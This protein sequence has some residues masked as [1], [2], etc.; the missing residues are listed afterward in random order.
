MKGNQILLAFTLVALIALSLVFLQQSMEKEQIESLGENA[1]ED[2]IDDSQI[3][4]EIDTN[5]IEENDDIEIGEM[6]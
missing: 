6:I 3:V 2:L 5:W 4:Q 1:N